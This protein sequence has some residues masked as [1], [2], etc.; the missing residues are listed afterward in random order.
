MSD[1]QDKDKA[2]PSGEAAPNVSGIRWTAASSKTVA[3]I[4]EFNMFTG[5]HYEG[6][7][8]PGSAGSA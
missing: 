3:P 8:G 1:P 7:E 2:G 6:P 5:I 4:R